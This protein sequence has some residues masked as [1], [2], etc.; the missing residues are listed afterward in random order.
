MLHIKDVFGSCERVQLDSRLFFEGIQ[1]F[2]VVIVE[3]VGLE[4]FLFFDS[5][6]FDRHLLEGRH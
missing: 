1:V 4:L 3:I 2:P 5:L 6:N